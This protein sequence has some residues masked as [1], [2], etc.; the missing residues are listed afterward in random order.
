MCIEEV[1]IFVLQKAQINMHNMPWFLFLAISVCKSLS[2]YALAVA[3]LL[4]KCSIYKHSKS[5]NTK[6]LYTF[7][8]LLSKLK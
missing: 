7:I 5:S 6:T 8:V 3:I 1:Y 4:A 2:V